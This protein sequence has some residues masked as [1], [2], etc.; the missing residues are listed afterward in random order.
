VKLG[1]ISDTLVLTGGL[2]A[3]KSTAARYIAGIHGFQR[4]SFVEEIWRPILRQ[5][6]VLEC[7]SSLQQLGIELMR[8][9]G[10]ER[11]VLDLLAR[12]NGG[13]PVV[14]DDVRRADV[15]AIIRG[16]RPSTLHLHIVAD[17]DVRY[18]RLVARDGVRSLDEQRTAES[19]ETEVTIPELE[20]IADEIV[21]NAGDLAAFQRSLDDV[22]VRRLGRV[23]SVPN[24]LE[25]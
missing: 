25:T 23:D 21:V 16:L 1:D 15:L 19:V 5:R 24:S 7:R 18:P 6:G 14:I 17:F 11:L 20:G 3:G 22:V 4:L 9:V 13:A 2:G 12:A 8:D 10:A